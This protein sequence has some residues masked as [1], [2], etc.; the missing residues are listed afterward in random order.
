M[1]WFFLIVGILKIGLAV[2]LWMASTTGLHEVTVAIVFG[3]G[4]VLIALA[5]ILDTLEKR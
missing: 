5:M 4:F 2:F 3:F 1:S